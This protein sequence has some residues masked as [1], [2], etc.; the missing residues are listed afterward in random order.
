MLTLNS[1]VTS[2]TARY[3]MVL[4]FCWVIVWFATDGNKQLG[5]LINKVAGRKNNHCHQKYLTEWATQISALCRQLQQFYFINPLTGYKHLP[6]RQSRRGRCGVIARV[7]SGLHLRGCMV[8]TCSHFHTWCL[9]QRK[10]QTSKPDIFSPVKR[11]R[12]WI[13]Y[14]QVKTTCCLPRKDWTVI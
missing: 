1:I 11:K 12:A 3:A 9:P 2:T 5:G 10:T 7:K 14:L 8:N 13:Q 6:F 4:N